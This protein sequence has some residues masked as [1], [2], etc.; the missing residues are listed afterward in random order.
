MLLN[1]TG[2]LVIWN[3]GTP[4][5]KVS[6]FLDF[7]LR[8]V[9]Q[10]GK[11]YIKDSGDFI[12]KIKSIQFIPSNAILVTAKLVGLYPSIPHEFGLKA[13]KNILD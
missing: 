10:S 13:L 7:Y 12:R 4:T 3:C 6:K 5:E 8:I 11:A 9:T 2:I 1:V